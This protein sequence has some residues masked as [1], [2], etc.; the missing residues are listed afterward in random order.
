MYANPSV[1]SEHNN[2]YIDK[3]LIEILLTC[4]HLPVVYTNIKAPDRKPVN[5]CVSSSWQQCCTL[6]LSHM[7]AQSQSHTHS[8]LSAFHFR[9]NINGDHFCEHH[10]TFLSCAPQ[11]GSPAAPVPPLRPSA[12][13]LPCGR[14]TVTLHYLSVVVFFPEVWVEAML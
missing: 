10:N 1:C 6:D 8:V 13:I 5:K 9:A 11:S 14:I 2:M 12:L 7:K 4:I 3:L